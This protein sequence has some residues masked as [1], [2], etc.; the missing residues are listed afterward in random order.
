[1]SG[2]KLPVSS[3]RIFKSPRAVP[4]RQITERAGP[5]MREQIQTQEGAQRWREQILMQSC[6]PIWTTRAGPEDCLRRMQS[7]RVLPDSGRE[8]CCADASPRYADQ[9]KKVTY[10]FGVLSPQL[11]KHHCRHHRGT[12]AAAL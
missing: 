8:G 4:T 9:G 1:M 11:V 6:L 2:G 5:K 3:K 7:W 12:N 10:E